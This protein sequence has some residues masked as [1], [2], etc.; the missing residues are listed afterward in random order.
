MTEALVT[1]ALAALTGLLGGL[2]VKRR[3]RKMQVSISLEESVCPRCGSTCP[4]KKD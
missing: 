1:H 3:K 2:V 4:P